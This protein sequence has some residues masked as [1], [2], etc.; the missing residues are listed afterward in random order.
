MYRILTAKIYF[1]VLLLL[2]CLTDLAILLNLPFLRPIFG[3]LYF[4]II[5]GMVILHILKLDRIEF[6]K[7]FV[8]SIGLSVSF[9]MFGGLLV[10]SFYP[11]ILKPVSLAPILVS[12]NI[13]LLI[14]TFV[15]YKR[16]KDDFDIKNIFN[17]KLDFKDKSIPLLL[18]PILF[19]FMSIFGIYLMNTQGNNVILLAML[20]LIMVYVILIT[21]LHKV[22]PNQAYPIAILMISIS[23]LFILPLRSNHIES[24]DINIEYF[25]FQQTLSN[26]HWDVSKF[27]CCYN[28][29]LSVGIL[30]AIYQLLLNMNGEYI[31]KIAYNLIFAVTPLCLYVLFKRYVGELY[32]FLASFLFVSQHRYINIIYMLPRVEI[33]LFS[34]ALAMMVFFDDEI[35]KMN[36]KILFLILLFA[37]I[38]SHYSTAYIFFIVLFLS[39]LI[40]EIVRKRIS[41]KKDLST[42]ILIVFFVLIFFWYG[43]VTEVPFT[44]GIRFFER[45]FINL[46]NFFIEES[47]SQGLKVLYGEG[48]TD[49]PNQ[50]FVIVFYITNLVISIGSLS[51]IRRYK[52]SNFSVEYISMMLVFLAIILSM[53]ALPYVSTGYSI[54]K[55]YLQALVL[56]APMIIIGSKTISKY[57]YPRSTSLIILLI[58]IPQFICGTYLVYQVFGVPYSYAFNSEGYKYDMTY[59]HDQEVAASQWLGNYDNPELRIYTDC[60][61]FKRLIGHGCGDMWRGAFKYDQES[62]FAEN[63][64]MR[65]GYIYLRYQ[66][67]VDGILIPK[68]SGI[69]FHQDIH[70][71]SEYHIFLN[72]MIYSN[73]GA[74]IY[75]SMKR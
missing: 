54:T 33:A 20:L 14:M 65:K 6:A 23:L 69:P 57:I 41:L 13:I 15:A 64:S 55:L 4:T 30:P 47:R 60:Y 45:T 18:F 56:L 42:K 36:K 37:V 22:V 8:L 26:Q 74:E 32:A 62:V 19:P 27:L 49:L 25:F 53:I 61:G 58:L 46:G 24:Q 35:D 2:L 9:L 7:K 5:P 72:D 21:L 59:V 73:G 12:F 16:N 68:Q 40:T 75:L 43:Q 48:L 39:W 11:F 31:Y 38:I 50:I 29:C 70:N 34:F 63:K 28:A 66:N 10:N 71:T 52:D 44:S 51:L 17:F 67:V 3:F 1:P